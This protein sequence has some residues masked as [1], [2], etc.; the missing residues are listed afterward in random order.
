VAQSTSTLLLTNVKLITFY[1]CQSKTAI[2]G[3]P[4]TQETHSM[5]KYYFFQIRKFSHYLK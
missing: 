2:Y 4:V 5:L 1:V 3:V